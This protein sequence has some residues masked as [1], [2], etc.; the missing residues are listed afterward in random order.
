MF[1]CIDI[2]KSSS[3]SYLNSLQEFKTELSILHKHTLQSDENIEA[4]YTIMKECITSF[5]RSRLEDSIPK[6]Q[7]LELLHKL[8]YEEMVI[9]VALHKWSFF[10][11]E[12][13]TQI[14]D[15][16]IATN[17]VVMPLQADKKLFS[18]SIAHNCLILCCL[19]ALDDYKKFFNGSG[20]DFDELSVSCQPGDSEL[21]RYVI[22][23][24]EKDK[25][26][27]IAF[28]GEVDLQAWQKT[29]I[30]SEGKK[31]ISIYHFTLMIL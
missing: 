15:T 10:M 7:L 26:L 20:H 28:L 24:R 21:E 30:I 14:A 2:M 8:C 19:V 3:K 31:K 13:I 23:K 6:P 4:K 18:E 1:L 5:F 12:E 9:P 22:A 27:Y 29:G 25:E 17:E 11:L 16:S